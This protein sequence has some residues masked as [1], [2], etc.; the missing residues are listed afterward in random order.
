M[1]KKKNKPK[2]KLDEANFSNTELNIISISGV[3]FS[4]IGFRLSSCQGL[5]GGA[6]IGI[7][8]GVFFIR[9]YRTKGKQKNLSEI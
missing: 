5:I 7:V 6:L 3:F 8:I 1:S 4:G 2:K 9:W